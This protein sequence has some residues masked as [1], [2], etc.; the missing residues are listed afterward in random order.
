MV[1]GALF[2]KL[3]DCFSFFL[4]LLNI[5]EKLVGVGVC[6]FDG[7]GVVVCIELNGGKRVEKANFCCPLLGFTKDFD[8]F[9]LLPGIVFGG[10][11]IGGGVGVTNMASDPC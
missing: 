2:L 10:I 4:R 9:F 8:G 1:D 6:A 3:V 11:M 7:L 5:S